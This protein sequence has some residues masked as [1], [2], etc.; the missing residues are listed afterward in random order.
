MNI[1]QITCLCTLRT[2]TNQRQHRLVNI[3]KYSLRLS[4][5]RTFAPG[6]YPRWIGH[7]VFAPSSYS[8][9][10]SLAGLF[11]VIVTATFYLYLLSSYLPPGP[12]LPKQDHEGDA[13]KSNGEDNQ[14]EMETAASRCASNACVIKT[15]VCITLYSA[16]IVFYQSYAKHT[17]D[18]QLAQCKK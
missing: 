10:R 4:R 7:A 16:R 6:R 2:F 18:V 15:V 9:M 17:E 14:S 8:V 3:H 5:I 13:A 1:K 11:A 12:Q